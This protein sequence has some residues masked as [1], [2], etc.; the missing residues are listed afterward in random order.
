M[1]NGKKLLALGCILTSVAVLGACGKSNK[2]ESKEAGTETITW[3]NGLHTATP[4]SGDI[5]EKMEEATGV[6]VKMNWVPAA[7]YGERLNASLG[8]N[9]LSDIV[10][11]ADLS[12]TTIRDSMKSGLFWDVEK[13]FADYP[14]LK[15]ISKERLDSARVDGH[16][17]GVPLQ[18][19]VSRY[20]VL[21]RQDWLDNLGLEVPHTIED[22]T[23]VIEAFTEDDPDQNGTKDTV[24]LVARNDMSDFNSMKTYFGAGNLFALEDGE[25]T[26]AFMQ[27]EYKE[28]MTFYKDL[29]DKGWMN[30]DFAVMAKNDEIDYIIQ[31]KAGVV[32]TGLMEARTYVS[33]A[34]GTPQAGMKWAMVNDMTYGNLE[35]MSY[36]DTNGGMGGW[37][38]IPKSE[39]KTEKELKRILKF[40]NDLMDEDVFKLMTQGEEGVHYKVN[41][42][43]A[44]ERIDN[45]KWTA[46][47]QPFNSSRPSELVA[48][49]KS[50]DALVN[51]Y[52]E[53][54]NENEAYAVTN[55]AQSLSSKTYDQQWS[56][57]FEPMKDAY[58]KYVM[59]EIDMD[60]YDDAIQ[61]FLDAGGQKVMDEYTASYEKNK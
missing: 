31:G 6:K 18:K 54:I 14:N 36:S 25:I 13:Y 21:V 3:M 34:E 2:A 19:P 45:D 60:G 7:S 1:R 27:D 17:Y 33:G 5:L 20:A 23:K 4:P 43:G 41:A 39:V 57:L 32:F 50:T 26:P 16:I 61:Q 9:D 46:E 29:Y 56:S 11:L 10:N 35:R 52:T 53:K 55:P 12:S 51:E 22:L 42:D 8:S 40:I 48:T 28:A 38:A 24:G 30:S 37:M 47:V 58:F 49:Y 44:Y 59:G 15:N